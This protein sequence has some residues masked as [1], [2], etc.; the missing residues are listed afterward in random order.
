LNKYL[1]SLIHYSEKDKN[2]GEKNQKVSGPATNCNELALLGYSLN[3]YHLIKKKDK[4]KYKTKIAVVYCQFQQLP[5][6]KQGNTV[7]G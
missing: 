5:S 3:G 2:Y 4:S 7:M 1:P 6:Q